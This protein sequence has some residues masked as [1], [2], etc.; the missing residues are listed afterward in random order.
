MTGYT[1]KYIY[2]VVYRSM[3]NGY[4]ALFYT[5]SDAER[6]WGALSSIDQSMTE[7]RAVDVTAEFL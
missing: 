4:F 5:K 7:V 1:D 6:F 2:G 3:R